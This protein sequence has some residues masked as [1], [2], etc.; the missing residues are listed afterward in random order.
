[1]TLKFLLNS[2]KLVLA[3]RT[4]TDEYRDNVPSSPERLP[5]PFFQGDMRRITLCPG[6]MGPSQWL[7]GLVFDLVD[8][9]FDVNLEAVSSTIPSIQH[10]HDEWSGPSS[11]DTAVP[12]QS[13]PRVSLGLSYT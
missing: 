5:L 12:N 3:L 2:D 10:L 13:G 8:S 4:T 1:M 7:P 9:R 6:G 11:S